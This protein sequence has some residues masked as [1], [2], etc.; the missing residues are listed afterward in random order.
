MTINTHTTLER[1]NWSC[2]WCGFTSDQLDV[3]EHIMTACKVRG[4]KR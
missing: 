4:S 1:Q 3:L 2:H